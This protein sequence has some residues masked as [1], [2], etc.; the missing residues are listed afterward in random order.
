MGSALLVMDPPFAECPGYLARD[1]GVECCFCLSPICCVYYPHGLFALDYSFPSP[2]LPSCYYTFPPDFSKQNRVLVSESAC[3][4]LDLGS[5]NVMSVIA[6]AAG[7]VTQLRRSS[8]SNHGDLRTPGCMG[9]GRP[10]AAQGGAGL[11][12]CVVRRADGWGPDS[13]WW[14][15]KT[16]CRLP[17]AMGLGQ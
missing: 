9:V 2:S 13:Q 17:R 1:F 8:R 15:R 4:L 3:V 6:A 11:G 10:I 7:I 12:C 5:V 16:S 14:R